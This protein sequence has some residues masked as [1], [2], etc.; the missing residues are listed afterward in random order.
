MSSSPK[1]PLCQALRSIHLCPIVPRAPT[2]DG[3]VDEVDDKGQSCGLYGI[4]DR[5]VQQADTC[6]DE[7]RSLRVRKSLVQKLNKI[8]TF[9]LSEK[10]LYPDAASQQTKGLVMLEK[11]KFK[12]SSIKCQYRKDTKLNVK[13]L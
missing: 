4:S 7:K 6:T 11:F 9:N 12:I 5:A 2:A 1:G 10:C 8:Y 13:T 3:D